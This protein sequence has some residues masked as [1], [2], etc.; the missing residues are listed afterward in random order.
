MYTHTIS[1]N[2]HIA[3]KIAF[4][5]DLRTSLMLGLKEAKN[6]ADEIFG[7]GSSTFETYKN[8]GQLDRKNISNL[9]SVNIITKK[10]V[11]EETK[12]ESVKVYT[13]QIN[14]KSGTQMTRDF[15]E[16][17]YK[18]EGGDVRVEW[19]EAPGTPKIMYMGVDDIES[20]YIIAN[21]T[22]TV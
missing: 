9:Y 7:Y 19:K 11:Q 15:E 4:I 22:I 16:F 18:K 10:H 3:N 12:Q 21:R 20:V 13:I 8:F 2:S 1:T 6:I 17:H 5:K 14:Y